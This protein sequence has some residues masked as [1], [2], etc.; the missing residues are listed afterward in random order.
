[1][2]PDRLYIRT[3]LP[4]SRPISAMKARIWLLQGRLAQALEWVREQGLSPDDDISFL[5]EYDYFT[6]AR[7][8]IAQYKKRP[9]GGYD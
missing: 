1:M 4:D 8:L 9:D 3:P 7:I 2:K 5:R 6:L